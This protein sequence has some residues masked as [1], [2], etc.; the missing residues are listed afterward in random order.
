MFVAS[1]VLASD[2][3]SIDSSV[4]NFVKQMYSDRTLRIMGPDIQLSVS[5]I[6][7]FFTI[8]DE[9]NNILAVILAGKKDQ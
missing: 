8:V 3:A 4:Y 6:P 5:E 2:N 9:N 1:S 7:V